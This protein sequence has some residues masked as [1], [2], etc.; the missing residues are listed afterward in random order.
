[1]V[2]AYIAI[3]LLTCIVTAIC[4]MIEDDFDDVISPPLFGMLAGLGWPL[5]WFALLLAAL[6]LLIAWVTKR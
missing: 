1:M 5:W 4:M 6:C 2:E 3:G